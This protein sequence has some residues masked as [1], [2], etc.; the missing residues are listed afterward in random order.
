MKKLGF[1]FCLVFICTLASSSSAQTTESGTLKI[2]VL[3]LQNAAEVS[4]TVVG[5]FADIVRGEAVKTLDAS[6]FSIMTRENILEMLPPGTD[7]K[8]CVGEECEIRIG[9]QIGADYI[10]TGEIFLLDDEYR[11]SL[12]AHHTKSAAF[13]S[14]RSAKGKALKDVEES[15]RSAARYIFT[16][17]RSNE[18]ELSGSLPQ[19][20]ETETRVMVKFE[21]EPA[22]A[23]VLLDTQPLCQETPCSRAIPIGS[24]R[25]SMVK[26]SYFAREETLDLSTDETIVWELKPRVGKLSVVA[27]DLKGNEQSGK[28]YIDGEYAGDTPGIIDALVGSRKVAVATEKGRWSGKIFIEEGQFKEIKTVVKGAYTYEDKRRMMV[29]RRHGKRLIAAGIGSFIIAGISYGIAAG[30]YS[31][32]L[33]DRDAGDRFGTEAHYSIYRGIANVGHVNAVVGTT[34]LT[35]GTTLLIKNPETLSDD[36]WKIDSPV[37]VGLTSFGIQ[38]FASAALF[39]GMIF[40]DYQELAKE[41]D[42]DMPND[43]WV[44]PVIYAFPSIF[45]S[46]VGGL[47][48]TGKAKEERS[49]KDT[50]SLNI[51]PKYWGLIWSRSF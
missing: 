40:N 41:E 13:L 10:V 2:A 14:E 50:L 38:L 15:V 49:R 6:R 4:D 39:S 44:I 8:K 43:F 11:V 18:G 16:K 35:T 7:L 19:P 17:V 21:S 24:A 48:W 3:E 33:N 31:A 34:L 51:S 37:A 25:I 32:Y 27:H 46:E 22:G 29:R 30:E 23:M 12:K 28:V 20:L 47:M 42:A 1:L 9:R 5:F 26:E 36:Y 45:I